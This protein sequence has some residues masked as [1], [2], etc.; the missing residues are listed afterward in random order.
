VRIVEMPET[1]SAGVL[2]NAGLVAARGDWITFLDDDDE[3]TRGKIDRQWQ[4]AQRSRL[5]VGLCQ[6]KFCLPLRRRV[7]GVRAREMMGDDLLLSFP[8]MPAVFHARAPEVQFDEHLGAG[9]DMHYFQRV[10]RH[11][12]VSSIFNVPE[13][14][15][16]VH[17]QDDVRVN[18]NA[19]SGWKAVERVL[20]DFG[21]NYSSAARRAYWLQSRLGYCKMQRGCLLEMLD[22]SA[23][24]V[25]ERQFRDARLILNS[26]LFKIP[27]ARRWIVS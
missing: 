16:D 18:L 6:I 9:E 10:L 17:A 4:E 19:E 12:N 1:K 20:S 25:R 15:V 5:Q 26:F 21:S 22:A 11:F 2:R 7:R 8:G 24:L 27:W 13:P 23:V 3:Y 14:L